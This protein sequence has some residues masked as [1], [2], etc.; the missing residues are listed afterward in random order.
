MAM[1]CFRLFTLPPFPPRPDFS[2]P[3][4]LRCMALF[5]LLLAALPYLAIR[6]LPSVSRRVLDIETRF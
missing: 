2:V 5:T 3:L 1:A 6:F 4:F